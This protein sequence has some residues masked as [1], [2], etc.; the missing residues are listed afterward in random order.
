MGREL[1]G[2]KIFRQSIS[3]FRD[4]IEAIR[5]LSDFAEDHATAIGERSGG[6]EILIT[7]APSA[8]SPRQAKEAA[9]AIA[10]FF[11]AAATLASEGVARRKESGRQYIE[12]DHQEK[13]DSLMKEMGS[14]LKAASTENF[15][16]AKYMLESLTVYR[17]RNRISILRSSLLTAAVG[18][19][20]VLFSMIVGMYFLLRPQ[21]LS[22]TEPQFSWDDIQKFDTLDDLR[23]FHADRQVEQLMW[24]GFDDWMEW[25]DKKLKVKFENISLDATLMR[26]VFQRRHVIVHNGGK[27]SRQYLNKVPQAPKDLSIGDSLEVSGE[28]LSDALDQLYVLGTLMA[29][30]VVDRL[31][32]N[33]EIREVIQKQLRLLSDEHLKQERWIS[34]EALCKAYSEMFDKEED[35]NAMRVNLWVAKKQ[36]LGIGSIKQDVSAWDTSSLR[37]DLRLAR[38]CLVDEFDSAYE[39]CCRL[40]SSGSL[41]GVDFRSEPLYRELRNWMESEGIDSPFSDHLDNASEVVQIIAQE[42]REDVAAVDSVSNVTGSNDSFVGGSSGG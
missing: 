12:E 14:R 42:I 17:K 6:V 25:L 32:K 33:P 3:R 29:S 36:R 31:I 38:L 9:A 30:A 2:L 26:E 24:K 35:R 11:T 40:A 18:D 37:D 16:A 22:S 27:V 21:A 4:A 7:P 28:Y 10:E 15:D 13:F 23:S 1:Q 19:F 39:M 41:R 8:P 34:T 20:E 5:D